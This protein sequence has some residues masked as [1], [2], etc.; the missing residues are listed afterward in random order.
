MI[1]IV[2]VFLAAIFKTFDPN[3][4]IPS[5]LG[6]SWH[7]TDKLLLVGSGTHPASYPLGTGGTFPG[8]KAPETDHSPPS[9]A[10]VKNGG[11]VPPLSHM[12]SC[13]SA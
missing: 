3:T 2:P 8:G 9:S 5:R 7:Y 12:S 6:V 4:N 1:R 13:L 10:K 11:A